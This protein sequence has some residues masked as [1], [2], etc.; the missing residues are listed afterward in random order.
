MRGDA[1]RKKKGDQGGGQP[2]QVDRSCQA[3]PIKT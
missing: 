3:A 2:R 1:D